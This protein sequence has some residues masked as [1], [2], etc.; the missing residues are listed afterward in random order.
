MK[1]EACQILNH[2]FGH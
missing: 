2:S 1:L